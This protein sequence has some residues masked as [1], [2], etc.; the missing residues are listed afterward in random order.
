MEYLHS[1]QDSSENRWKYLQET[2]AFPRLEWEYWTLEGIV[3]N[4]ESV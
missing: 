1:E 2:A 3:C 4:V